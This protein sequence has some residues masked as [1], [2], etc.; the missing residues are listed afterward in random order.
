MRRIFLWSLLLVSGAVVG[1]AAYAHGEELQSLLDTSGESI[2]DPITATASETSSPYEL[3]C[4]LSIQ[5]AVEVPPF[6]Y[7]RSDSRTLKTASGVISP[8]RMPTVAELLQMCQ[9]ANPGQTDNPALTW[10]AEA[11][12]LN[13]ART[14]LRESNVSC[15]PPTPLMCHF[16]CDLYPAHPNCGLERKV[17]SSA[18]PS[19]TPSVNIQTGAVTV[20][21]VSGST[22]P[23]GTFPLT[24]GCTECS[25]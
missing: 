1:E 5:V 6:I 18:I 23:G 3:S 24:I 2:A 9:T 14:V 4:G 11:E 25:R 8:G 7:R 13:A 16:G 21:C 10:R 20:A 17:T 22:A 15:A 12:C 19:G